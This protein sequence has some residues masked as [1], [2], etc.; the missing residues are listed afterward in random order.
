MSYYAEGVCDIYREEFRKARKEHK[1]DACCSLI[2]PGDYYCNLFTLYDGN[3]ENIKRCGSC[4]RTHEHLRAL[5]RAK[6]IDMWPDDRL[7][8]GLSYEGEWGE[9][10]EEIGALPFLG[11]EERGALLKPKHKEKKA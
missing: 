7:G 9:L 8:C 6:D 1:C 4:Q 10:P 3:T 11:P 5:C 2:R